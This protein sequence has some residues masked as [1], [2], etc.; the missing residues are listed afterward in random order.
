MQMM[1]HICE[2]FA[3]DYDIRFNNDKSVAMHIGKGFNER[4]AALVIDNKDIRY[5]SEMKCLGIHV[6]AAR[7][8][9][10]SVEHVRLKFYRTFNCIYAKSSAADSEMVTVVLLKSY[11]LP[12]LLYGVEAM[13]LSTNVKSLENCYV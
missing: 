5:V 6:I 1:L 8:L 12:F 7:H 2:T 10:F 13:S 11:C 9:K 3:G 4:C